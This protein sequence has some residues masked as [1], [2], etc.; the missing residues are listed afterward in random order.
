MEPS[1]STTE[2]S[3]CL[4]PDR[5]PLFPLPNIVFFPRTHLPLHIFEPRYRQMVIDVTTAGNCIGMALFK[6][7]WQE[8]YYGNPAIYGLG[9]VGRVV[10]IQNLADGRSNIMLRG[11]CRYKILGEEYDRAPYRQAR[12]APVLEEVSEPLTRQVR[13]DLLAILHESLAHRD[14]DQA[15]EGLESELSDEVLVNIL[16]A[17]LDFTPLEKQL[18]L[19]AD[20]V[21]QRARRLSDLLQFKR[22]ERDDRKGR[23]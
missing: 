14:S 1:C 15:W 22:Y 7:G 10:S 21:R 6:E 20:T 4:F 19:E 11:L 13:A 9:C 5:I 16:S 2:P 18:L 17:S 8:N 23:G 12:I 3:S